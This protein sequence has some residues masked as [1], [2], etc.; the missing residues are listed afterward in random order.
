MENINVHEA[1]GRE[2]GSL[3]VDKIYRVSE[4]VRWP[5]GLEMSSMSLG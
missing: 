1:E 4:K 3:M 2:L 5:N